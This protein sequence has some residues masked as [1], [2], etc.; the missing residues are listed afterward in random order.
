MSQ[1][2]A[3]IIDTA[4]VAGSFS[5]LPRPQARQASSTR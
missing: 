5:I 4:V 2:T 3:D 1:A